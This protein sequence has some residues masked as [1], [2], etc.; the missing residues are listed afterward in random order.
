[1]GYVWDIVFIDILVAYDVMRV[2]GL[3]GSIR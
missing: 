2:Y 3:L 1:M